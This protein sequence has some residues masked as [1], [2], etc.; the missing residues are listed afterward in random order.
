MTGAWRRDAKVAAGELSPCVRNPTSTAPAGCQDTTRNAMK[1]GED[2]TVSSRS[3]V[4]CAQ[5]SRQAEEMGVEEMN[6]CDERSAAT[7]SDVI[8]AWALA[9]GLLFG[10]IAWSLF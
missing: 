4:R 6:D 2:G 7:A 5:L 3:N 1:N 8:V 9:F 10:L